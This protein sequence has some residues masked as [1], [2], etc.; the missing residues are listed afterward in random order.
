[1]RHSW[2][3]NAFWFVNNM[4]W[5]KWCRFVSPFLFNISYSLPLLTKDNRYRNQ[6]FY[7]WLVD[8]HTICANYVL[9]TSLCPNDDIRKC[10][11]D[12]KRG[13]NKNTLWNVNKK[14]W[15]KWF[16]MVQPFLFNNIYFLPVLT[17]DT[18]CPN[19]VFYDCLVIN[20]AWNLVFLQIMIFGNVCSTEG[21]VELNTRFETW[22]TRNDL[23][24][25]S[26][27]TFLI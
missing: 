10:L 27:F 4:K 23:S 18:K 13:S 24:C 17:M 15:L 9:E 8:L 21:V 19:K 12:M 11:L 7:V 16:K 26:F 22:I 1:M 3:E 25:V 6:V 2:T 14:E 5:R 20:G